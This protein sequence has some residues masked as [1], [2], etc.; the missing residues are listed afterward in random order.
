MLKK[1]RK[2]TTS[3]K[4]GQGYTSLPFLFH[5]A[6]IVATGNGFRYFGTTLGNFRL[7]FALFLFY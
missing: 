6:L 1:V 7:S 3:E 4:L 5:L 2:K